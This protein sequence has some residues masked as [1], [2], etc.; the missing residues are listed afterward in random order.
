MNSNTNIIEYINGLD[1][2]HLRNELQKYMIMCKDMMTYHDYHVNMAKDKEKSLNK[3][4]KALQEELKKSKGSL[5]LDGL[6][7]S[8]ESRESREL[9][10][11]ISIPIYIIDKLKDIKIKAERLNDFIKYLKETFV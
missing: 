2:K 6:E 8:G 9:G 5:E 11:K 7:E 4:I 1:K 10:D 3:K